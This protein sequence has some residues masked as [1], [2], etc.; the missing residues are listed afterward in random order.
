MGSRE[1]VEQI[2]FVE[3]ARPRFLL[4]WHT[5]NQK[6]GTNYL[7]AMG[8]LP[9]FPDVCCISWAG[10]HLALEFKSKTGKTR[11]A[12]DDVLGQLVLAG[13]RTAVVRSCAEAVEFAEKFL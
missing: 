5:P 9:G 2:A 10:A 13:W 8:V 11:R 7:K 1:D 6:A 4:V 3:W 12:Q